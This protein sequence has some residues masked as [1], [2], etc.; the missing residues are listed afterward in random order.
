M[1]GASLSGQK[2]FEDAEPLLIS[3]YNGMASAPRSTNANNT[4]R[5]TRE[6]AGEAVV[7]MYADW[8]RTEKQNE[9]IE[10]TKT[11]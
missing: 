8:G 7:Q 4:S 2:K 10:R 5:F 6:Q 3:G 1:L 9:W 11:R